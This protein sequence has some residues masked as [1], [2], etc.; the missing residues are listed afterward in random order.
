MKL[1]EVRAVFLAAVCFGF[2]SQ[3]TAAEERS[4]SDMSHREMMRVMGMDDRAAYHRVLVEKLE[5]QAHDGVTSVGWEGQAYYGGDYDKLGL[6][7]HGSAAG[8]SDEGE[9]ELLWDHIATRWWST[10][11]GVRHDW[12]EAGPSRQW[13]AAGVQGLAP[14]FFEIEATAY[15]SENGRTALRLKASY[16]LLLSQRL[17]L[18]PQFELDAYGKDE[19]ERASKSGLSDFE[20]GLRLRYEIRR[21][22][23]PYLGIAWERALGNT[24]DL[25]RASGGD[26]SAV[27]A[28]AG[29]RLS[30]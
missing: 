25:R 9:V 14:Y 28:V 7:T 27:A 4:A 21:E 2:A 13:L 8:G 24:S 22:F 23:A 12:A 26:V 29:V 18:Q 10:Q 11:I 6:K 5:A 16:E 3:T 17:I 1:P 20:L 30:F 15:A 19:P